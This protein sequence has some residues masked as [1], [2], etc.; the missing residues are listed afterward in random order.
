MS[1]KDKASARQ[2]SVCKIDCPSPLRKSIAKLG[3][4]AKISRE[5]TTVNL[6]TTSALGPAIPEDLATSE[7]PVVLSP[8]VASSGERIYKLQR[9]TLLRRTDRLFAGLLFFQ[10]IAGVMAAL[11][12]TPK[13][14]IGA[15][16]QLHPH[17]WMAL[18]LGGVVSA[19]PIALA[20]LRP[21]ERVTRYVIAAAQMIWSSLLIHLT[22]GRIETHFHVFG[23]L[24]FLAFYFDWTVLVPA[25]IVVAVDHFVRGVYFPQSV[26]G[27]AIASHWRWLEHAGW[28]VFED[29]F[30]VAS[31]LRG[32]RDMRAMAM[33]TAQL[34]G[35]NHSIEAVVTER[36]TELATSEERFR[37]MS[38]SSPV[39]IYQ[40]DA[41]GNVT[42][43]NSQWQ[44]MMGLE[45]TQ[46]SGTFWQDLIHPA[47]RDRVL[48]E[49][50]HSLNKGVDL[51]VEFRI[52]RAGSGERWVHARS[53]A[54]RDENGNITGRVGTLED[55]T[56]RKHD[57]EALLRGAYH[58]SLT[59]LPNRAA[60]I[61]T[62]ARALAH[63]QR[64]STYSFA[65]LFLDL[66]RFKVV[67]DSLGHTL[68]DQVLIQ[69]AERL[70]QCLRTG[71]MVARLGGDE[72]TILL[73]DITGPAEATTTAERI[74]E[75]FQRSFELDGHAF[76]LSCSIGITFSSMGYENAD[77]ILR[78]ADAAMYRAKA[79]GRARYQIFDKAMHERAMDR[80][81]LETDLRRALERGELWV[82]YQPIVSLQSGNI[83]AFEALCRWNHPERGLV[84]PDD[85]IGLAE[86]TGLI[87]AVG[88]IV[89]QEACNWLMQLARRFPDATKNISISVNVTSLQLSDAKFVEAV[90][91]VLR[92]SGLSAHHLKLEITESML[93]QD[94]ERAAVVLQRLRDL[95][96]QIS[97][98]DFGT[99]YSSL[100]Y[101]HGFPIDILKIDRSFVSGAAGGN[102]EVVRAIVA[103]AHS[104]GMGVVAEGIES[105]EQCERLRHIGCGQGQGNHF[106]RPL[107]GLAAAELMSY[108]ADSPGGGLGP[109]SSGS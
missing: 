23:S 81:R 49:W 103:L 10:W 45:E 64:R 35:L 41:Q 12:I 39:G 60:F 67:N 95:N 13:T 93:M 78:D 17:F 24:A 36:T 27:V 98:D 102:E 99:G 48:S 104:L 86:E 68:G 58:D 30:L 63:R 96:V 1:S 31:C 105:P 70:I 84:M 108:P 80:L 109:T 56:D 9:E 18:I 15:T 85:F 101:L 83:E 14:W 38:A 77:D 44:N 91:S 66:D 6:S 76:F 20:I 11:Y 92:E 72:F 7:L 51:N 88:R 55:I 61:E 54:M 21:G 62:L 89:L 53:R 65:V 107:T 28:V 16:N 87:V 22:G 94:P 37:A 4:C 57:A 75:E 25:T 59:G 69:A 46:C 26:F 106:S 82:A 79:A 32:V 33:R 5:I 34:M 50:K 43:T 90:E 8:N 71:D 3:A 2:G 74:E 100:A 40:A 29:C 19:L 47:E 73:D 52:V 97:L 42:Y